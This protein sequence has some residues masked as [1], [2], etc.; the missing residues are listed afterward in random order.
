MEAMWQELEARLSSLEPDVAKEV[1]ARA[2]EVS[3]S[4]RAKEAFR[5]QSGRAATPLEDPLLKVATVLVEEKL[6]GSYEEAFGL[7]GVEVEPSP[8]QAEP[9]S[10]QEDPLPAPVEAGEKAPPRAPAQTGQSQSE[11]AQDAKWRRAYQE[12]FGQDP[13]EDPLLYHVRLA[14]ATLLYR[15]EQ[16]RRKAFQEVLEAERRLQESRS[17]TRELLG[18]EPQV[19]V[20]AAFVQLGK[21]SAQLEE[22]ARR[23]ERLEEA[24]QKEASRFGGVNAALRLHHQEIRALKGLVEGLKAGDGVDWKRVEMA[25]RTAK[26]E[27]IREVEERIQGAT[28]LW[29]G[30]V[31]PRLK[32]LEEWAKRITEAFR[33]TLE[34]RERRKGLF[35]LFGGER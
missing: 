29:R 13:S 5:A 15:P 3:P 22:M 20:G 12:V 2:R 27:T 6:V 34:A 17:R 9:A 16:G 21:L 26:A 14:Q 33:R 18:S 4:R 28:D 23:V 10:A 7:L 25:V 8:A 1:V 30:E 24:V 32:A 35:G 19:D 11:A 31:E